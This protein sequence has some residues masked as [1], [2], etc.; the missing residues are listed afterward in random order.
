VRAGNSRERTYEIHGNLHRMRCAKGCTS[1]QY[2]VPDTVHT[3]ERNGVLHED[4]EPQLRCPRCDGW[5]RP[6]VLWFDECYDEG[7]Y[8]FDSSLRGAM[9]ADVLIVVGTSGA[10]NLPMQVGGIAAQRGAVILDI[11]PQANPFSRMADQSPRGGALQGPAGDI[12][13]DLVT[14]L[15][16]AANN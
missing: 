7:W 8:R 14:A 3:P 1:E 11:N 6:H 9:D 4:D 2:A 15:A 13:P 10:T 16:E 12:L 5:A